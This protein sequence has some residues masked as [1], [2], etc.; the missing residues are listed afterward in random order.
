MSC[1]TQLF[2]D[3]FLQTTF[4]GFF[5]NNIVD[6]LVAFSFRLTTSFSSK[7]NE[8]IPFDIINIDTHSGWRK[9]S[10]VYNA[11]VSGVYVISY[12][13]AASENQSPYVK[14]LVNT[15]DR[16][17]LHL[18][19][20]GRNGIETISRM[21]LTDLKVGDNLAIFSHGEYGGVYSDVHCQTSMNGFLYKPSRNTPVSWCVILAPRADVTLTGPVD[22]VNFDTILVNQEFGWNELTNRFIT[23]SAGVYYIHMTAGIPGTKPTKMELLV[24]G[25]PFVNVYRKFTSHASLDVRSRSVILRLQQGDE[26][27]ICLPA[28]F[29]LQTNDN[30]YIGFAGFRLYQ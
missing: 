10:N 13:I 11:R 26:L 2:S 14:L 22:P 1:N 6:P 7:T 5:I 3:N 17:A 15:M 16:G 20:I 30:G 29:Y 21:V 9:S 12:S 27:R 18:G 8:N 25:L 24:N 4:A 19:S 28:S 23:P